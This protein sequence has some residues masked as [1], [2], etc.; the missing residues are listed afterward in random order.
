MP[1]IHI[2]KKYGTRDY[3]GGGRSSARETANWVAAGSIAKQILSETKIKISAYV[4]QVGSLK[5]KKIINY[6]T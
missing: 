2:T 4:S 6:L 1:I 5:L 3:R